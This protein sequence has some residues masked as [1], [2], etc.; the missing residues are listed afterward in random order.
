[1]NWKCWLFGHDIQSGWEKVPDRFLQRQFDPTGIHWLHSHYRPAAMWSLLAQFSPKDYVKQEC[2]CKRCRVLIW[3]FFP[4]DLAG[5]VWGPPEDYKL[6]MDIM[7]F[8]SKGIE[9]RAGR[10]HWI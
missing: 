2:R 8:D 4:H 9:A 3:E 5:R 6:V 7:W 10:G 1:M